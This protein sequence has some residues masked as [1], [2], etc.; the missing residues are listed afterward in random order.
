MELGSGGGFIKDIIPGIVTSD[1]ILGHGIDLNFSALRIP[2]RDGA[3]GAFVMFNVMHHIPDSRVFL[4]EAGRCLAPGGRIIMIEPAN[5]LFGRFIYRN[6]HHEPFLPKAGWSFDSA[7]PLS[8]A[9]GALP[10]IVF[11]RDR[12]TFETE[13]PQ[14]RI[15]RIKFHTPFRYL[16]SGGFTLKQLLPSFLSPAS[17]WIEALLSPLNPFL[18]MFM[19]VQ[20]TR[21]K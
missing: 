4:S 16:L 13:Y 5:S 21:M 7:G 14:F 12:K 3:V 6:F 1:M 8:S 19:T 9:N 15:D 2:F 11:C 10:W 17:R 18:G 20:L